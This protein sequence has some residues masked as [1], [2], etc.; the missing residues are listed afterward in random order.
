MPD[1]DAPIRLFRHARREAVFVALVLLVS[2]TWTLGY[3]YLRGYK[4]DPQSWIVRSGLAVQ[5]DKAE[6]VIVGLPEWVFYGILLPWILCSV[7]TLGFGL[8]GMPDDDLGAEAEEEA[9]N[10]T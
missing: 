3:C 10:G 6:K 2:L 8:F 9:G 4:H 5:A 1:P 7:L